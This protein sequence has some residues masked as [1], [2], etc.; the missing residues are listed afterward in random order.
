M[1][2]RF[3]RL[4]TPKPRAGAYSLVG[5]ATCLDFAN[6]ASGRGTPKLKDR[7]RRFDDLMN[8]C[9]AA[10]T[11]TAEE[12]DSLRRRAQGEPEEA[13][14]ALLDAVALR[15]A[16]YGIGRALAGDGQQPAS[17]DIEVVR[18][19]AADA[20]R[21]AHFRP[22]EQGFAWRWPDQN[23]GCRWSLW[24]IAYSAAM[25]FTSAETRRLKQCPAAD[26]GWLFL[27]RSK[28]LSRRWCDMQVCGNRQKARRHYG[29]S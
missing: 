5:G 19:M 16:V 29:R 14:A 28:N 18:T 11:L 26:C 8:W 2:N 27:D 25:L 9:A 3:K 22:G 23:A 12:A 20:L 17:S 4:E 1:S 6:T 10:G 13:A 7:L 24:P 15:E 21:R